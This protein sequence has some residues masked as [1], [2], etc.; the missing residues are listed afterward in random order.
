ML[1][2]DTRIGA[3]CVIDKLLRATFAVCDIRHLYGRRFIHANAYVLRS[4]ASC[5]AV[6]RRKSQGVHCATVR[7]TTSA[8]V[9]A[10]GRSSAVTP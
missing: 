1:L 2:F 3:Y 10:R 7:H 9:G 6:H 8:T 4:A 5:F